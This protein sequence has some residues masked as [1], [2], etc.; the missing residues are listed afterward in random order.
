M[1]IE[2]LR[3]FCLAMTG[4]TEKTPFANFSRRFESIL[5]FYVM[6]HMFCLVDMSDFCCVNVIST[7]E[8]SEEIR[9]RY[10]SADVATPKNLRNWIALHLDGDLPDSVIYGLVERAYKIVKS[11]YSS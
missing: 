9:M 2:E 5:V 7:P 11:R 1:N 10:A 3:D 8:E 6:G 4:V